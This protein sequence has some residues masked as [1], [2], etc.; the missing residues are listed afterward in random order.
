[1]IKLV[2]DGDTILVGWNDA[3]QSGTSSK[4]LEGLRVRRGQEQ[5]S[6]S[7]SSNSNGEHLEKAWV[8]WRGSFVAAVAVTINFSSASSFFFSSGGKIAF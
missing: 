8:W 2:G 5:R 7:S 3:S 6:Y 1:M 4:S